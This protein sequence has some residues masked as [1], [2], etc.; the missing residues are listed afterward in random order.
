MCTYRVCF[1]PHR[2]ANVVETKTQISES[3]LLH[4]WAWFFS[5]WMG[6]GDHPETYLLKALFC[7]STPSWLKVVGWWWWWVVAHEIILSSTGSWEYSLFHIP[8][9]NSQFPILQHILA[10]LVDFWSCYS[11]VSLMYLWVLG[12]PPKALNLIK[13]TKRYEHFA[14][15]LKSMISPEDN[16]RSKANCAYFQGLTLTTASLVVL[17]FVLTLQFSV[18]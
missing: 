12:R 5:R 16:Q 10:D 4:L 7:Q 6:R 9:P 8:I 11:I 18:R 14:L 17:C 15:F 3:G 2:R 1:I 13:I